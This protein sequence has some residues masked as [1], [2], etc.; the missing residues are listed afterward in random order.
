MKNCYVYVC[1]FVLCLFVPLESFSTVW[2]RHHYLRKAAI[3]PLYLTLIKTHAI[4]ACCRAYG[5]W[6][7]KIFFGDLGLSWHGIEP[8]HL[9]HEEG[10]CDLYTCIPNFEMTLLRNVFILLH[11]H[12]QC[13]LVYWARQD[14]IY[15]NI[16]YIFIYCIFKNQF[17]GKK[18][19]EGRL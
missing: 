10:T 8:R 11:D 4:H 3:F 18:R 12:V 9:A 1:M 7:V 14:R 16:Y 13:I 17:G 19:G 15:C 2:I 6:T 5:S